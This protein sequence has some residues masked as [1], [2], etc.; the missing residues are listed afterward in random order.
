MFKR[1]SI[2]AF[3]IVL[4]ASLSGT[5]SSSIAAESASALTGEELVKQA[6]AEGSVVWWTGMPQIEAT[7]IASAFEAKYG[8]PVTIQRAAANALFERFTTSYEAGHREADVFNVLNP[9]MLEELSAQ[10]MLDELS[11]DIVDGVDPALKAKDDRWVSV[12]IMPT[13]ISYN[14]RLEN[15]PSTWDDL[16]DPQYRG[17]IGL[18]DP[19]TNNGGH[20]W[21]YALRKPLGK[22]VAWMEALKAQDVKYYPETTAAA[23]ALAAGEVMVVANMLDARTV[24][25]QGDGAPVANV[26]PTGDEEGTPLA[27]DAAGVIR[28][29]PNPAAAQLLV[30]FLLSPE[31]GQVVAEHSF[32]Y[33]AVEN[34]QPAGD[35]P[36]LDELSIVDVAFDDMFAGMVEL[37]DEMYRV[38]GQ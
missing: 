3:C 13:V 33:V 14:T 23:N 26:Y 8:I 36:R 37:R 28:D 30:K 38:F 18:V 4:A 5:Y 31:G 22:D 34:V 29:G 1:S 6:Q 7:S 32:A 24:N 25:L 15:P 9:A 27:L 35:R 10:D 21:Y 11:R 16:L 19:R 17:K 12:R 20:L 2:S